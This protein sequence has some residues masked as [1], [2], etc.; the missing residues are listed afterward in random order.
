MY[1]FKRSTHFKKNY[2][3]LVKN[4]EFIESKIINTLQ[5]LAEDPFQISLRTHNVVAKGIG[6]SKSTTVTGDIRI[7]WNFDTDSKTILLLLNI[8]GHS[9]SRSV[10]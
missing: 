2:K 3:K 10:Y 7:I 5:K 6:K 4:N 1:T 9:G 8:G